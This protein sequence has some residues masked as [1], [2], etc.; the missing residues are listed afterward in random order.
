MDRQRGWLLVRA[1]VT[2]DG[3]RWTPKDDDDRR[4]PL[5]DELRDVFVALQ[6]S[7][8]GDE[9][10]YLFPSTPG[11]WRAKNFARTTLSQLKRLAKSTGIPAEKLTSHNFRRYFVSQCADSGIDILCV[12]EWVGHSDWKMVRRYYRLRDKHAQASMRK[13]TTETPGAAERRRTAPC[14][15]S[16]EHLGSSD[17]GAN[18][19]RQRHRPQ[20]RVRKEVATAAAE[21]VVQ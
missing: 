11:R 9:Q 14:R 17:R 8:A 4:L 10:R 15:E 3:T 18:R 6:P 21:S 12:M 7:E 2:H 20:P 5:N 13:F 1:K 19:K 16:G